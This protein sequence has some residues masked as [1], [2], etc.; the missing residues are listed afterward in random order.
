MAFE[1]RAHTADIAVA[2]FGATLEETFES[3]ADGLAAASCDEIPDAI[4]DGGERF[5]LEVAAENR[6]ALL[7]EYLDELIYL[8][9]V[10]LEL[11][12]ENR[13]RRLEEPG[14]NERTTAGDAAEW[15]L[16]ATARGVPLD[17]IVAREIKAV[18]YSEMRLERTDDGW[19]AYVV[20]DV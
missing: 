15:S 5:S 6:E 9:D 10:R 7:F 18:T 3:L 16:E 2:A 12:V 20:F 11:P 14:G 8:R 4:D 1:L 19:E 17:R 13:I